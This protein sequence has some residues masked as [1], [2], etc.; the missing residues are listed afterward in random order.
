MSGLILQLIGLWLLLAAFVATAQ[1]PWPALN[2]TPLVV[3][4]VE[5]EGGIETKPG[6]VSWEMASNV[7]VGTFT[8]RVENAA[9]NYETSVAGDQRTAPV[10]FAL[11]TNLFKVRAERGAIYSTWAMKQAE[12]FPTNTIYR[13]PVSGP[14][15]RGPWTNDV[16]GA[17]APVNPRYFT[18]LLTQSNR[19]E[20]RQ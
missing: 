12:A 8:V 20:I 11:G 18:W 5:N 16:A 19:W 7:A 1:P 9:T 2:W 15:H 3:A 14:T 10:L 4:D 6:S 13:Q 17:E